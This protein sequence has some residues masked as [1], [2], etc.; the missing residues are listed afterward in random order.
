[1]ACDR[2]QRLLTCRGRSRG[3]IWQYLP[4]QRQ[5][6]LL[7]QGGQAWVLLVG[8]RDEWVAEQHT[9]QIRIVPGPCALQ[10]RE[11]VVRLLAQ[12]VQVGDEI[13][14]QKLTTR[15]KP[16]PKKDDLH[17]LKASEIAVPN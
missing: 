16:S 3:G 13:E 15:L 1:M 7:A 4:R 11:H 12:G 8:L 9:A 2:A 14:V 17:K 10:R 6:G 5:A